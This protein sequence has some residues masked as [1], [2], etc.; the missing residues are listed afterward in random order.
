MQRLC[1]L[2]VLLSVTQSCGGCEDL[3]SRGG[4][5]WVAV[6]DESISCSKG[7]GGDP[8]IY[9]AINGG[10]SDQYGLTGREACCLCGGGWHEP[11]SKPRE[12]PNAVA[13]IST[14]QPMTAESRK[15][16]NNTAPTTQPTAAQPNAAR[17][18]CSR[19]LL[20][21]CSTGHCDDLNAQCVSGW[22]GPVCEC[23]EPLCAVNGVCTTTAPTNAPT[24][25]PPTMSPSEVRR[26]LMEFYNATGGPRWS[27]NIG[28]GS[29][30]DYCGWG[31]WTGVLC[32]FHGQVFLM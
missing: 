8:E 5:P 22:F 31:G 19:S 11:S 16:L 4:N 25:A 3:F 2:L 26:L 14:E 27:K 15:L 1:C 10:V 23:A 9:C 30:T 24:T 32:D 28:W 13:G 7:Y 12:A 17:R 6:N 18:T 21:A 29:A 20:T